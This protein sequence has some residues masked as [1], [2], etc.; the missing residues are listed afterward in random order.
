[1]YSLGMTAVFVLYGK[2]LPAEVFENEGRQAFIAKLDC[3]KALRDVLRKAV[4]ADR[5]RRYQRMADLRKDLE[6][7]S[8]PWLLT[9][10]SQPAVS[11]PVAP[12]PRNPSRATQ[13]GLAGVVVVGAGIVGLST[14]LN[15][16]SALRGHSAPVVVA[17]AP[18]A[19]VGLPDA[20]L[21][22]VFPQTGGFSL[23]SEPPGATVS[24]DGASLGQVTPMRVQSVLVGK[25]SLALQLGSRSLTQEIIVEGGKTTDI[26]LTF[27]LEIVGK[28]VPE[29]KPAPSKKTEDREVRHPKP[30]VAEMAKRSA[31][32][33]VGFLRINS[34]PWSKI[35]VDGVDV[36]LTTPQTAYRMSPGMHRVMLYNPEIGFH[37]TFPVHIIAGE[38]LTVIKDFRYSPIPDE[39]D[40]DTI[41]TVLRRA[42]FAPCKVEGASGIINV[43]F[44]IGNNGNVTEASGPNDC[45]VNVIKHVKF[46]AFV[47]GP[48][49][50]T[51]PAVIR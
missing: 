38:T 2:R 47:G 48:M 5:A 28:S 31:A 19:G 27:P 34:K 30:G 11:P 33:S 21:A 46:P 44:V 7:A 3:P 39:L 41:K 14:Y 36:D 49:S 16:P 35:F 25:H 51:Y 32:H 9:K 45:V 40:G 24:L 50:L 18:D 42:N 26:K 15:R 23:L 37:E 29:Q 1:M 10:P 17:H 20:S 13:F 6:L 12:P 4:D 22:Q 43:K 8:T